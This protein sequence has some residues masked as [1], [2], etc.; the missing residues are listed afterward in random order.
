MREVEEEQ[1]NGEY[2]ELSVGGT[3]ITELRY[4]DD[5]ALFSTT[6]DGFNNHVEAV[7][8]CRTTYTLAINASKTKI[9]EF[10]KWQENTNI[11]IYNIHVELPISG[12]NVYIQTESVISISNDGS[13]S[14]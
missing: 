1:S 4:A 13:A 6:P 14:A 12:R 11:V 2:D 9:M 5:T 7:N 10:D 8:Q 3:N